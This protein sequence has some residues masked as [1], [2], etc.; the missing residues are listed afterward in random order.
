MAKNFKQNSCKGKKRKF[1][2]RVKE[3]FPKDNTPQWYGSD[4][5]LAMVASLPFSTV[6]GL[7]I[8][9]FGDA[10]RRVRQ[11]AGFTY[12]KTSQ[13][14]YLVPG[15]M[16][17]PFIPVYGNTNLEENKATSPLAIAG[18]SLFGYIRSKI[19]GSRTYEQSDVIIYIAAVDA[20]VTYL[21]HLRK[22]LM[23]WNNYRTYNRYM[24]E[25]AIQMMG[26]DAQDIQSNIKQYIFI[27]NTAVA[28]LNS[29]CIPNAFSLLLR[30]AYLSATVIADDHSAKSQYYFYKPV[31][32]YRYDATGSVSGGRLVPFTANFGSVS[33]V[34]TALNSMISPLVNDDDIGT[35]SG[36]IRRAFEDASLFTL[37]A[38]DPD[39]MTWNLEDIIQKDDDGRFAGYQLKNNTILPLTD[40]AALLSEAFDSGN[41]RGAYDSLYLTQTDN[42]LNQSCKIVLTKEQ[43][44]SGLVPTDC[45]TYTFDSGLYVYDDKPTPADVMEFTRGKSNWKVTVT[46]PTADDGVTLE[47][48]AYG[49][50]LFLCPKIAI[51]PTTTS[52]VPVISTSQSAVASTFTNALFTM[53]M[54]Q[55]F[56]YSPVLPCL[57]NDKAANPDGAANLGFVGF[58]DNF[59]FVDEPTLYR[60]HYIALLGEYGVVNNTTP[61]GGK[62]STM[63]GNN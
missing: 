63:K 52:I 42:Y 60:M 10:E 3:D 2:P 15:L 32:S 48:T 41:E 50:E 4:A 35:I 21:A 6:T 16:C 24:P 22:M 51:G 58:F 57:V 38:L 17:C 30:H 27:Y 36:D 25:R 1:I 11:R 28:K 61:A 56:R 59:T 44:P 39:P 43:L 8:S 12:T 13:G 53:Q 9:Y 18:Q 23:F 47:P 62:I 54:C 49:T 33:Q 14:T 26:G 34:Q 46:G 37:K 19:S 7:P 40:D 29:L 45:F 20:L 31:V 55:Y 5:D